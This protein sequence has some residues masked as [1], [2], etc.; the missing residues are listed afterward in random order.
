MLFRWVDLTIAVRNERV[1][2]GDGGW[3]D[4]TITRSGKRRSLRDRVFGR[5]SNR[6]AFNEVSFELREVDMLKRPNAKKQA[7]LATTVNTKLR[8]GRLG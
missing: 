8:G 6:L 3:E 2:P 7:N 5:R 4:Y 1:E